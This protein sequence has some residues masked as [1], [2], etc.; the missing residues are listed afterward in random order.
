MTVDPA[1]SGLDAGAAN[2]P[3]LLLADHHRETEHACT[4]LLA[5]LYA[6]DPRELVEGFRCFERAVLD[7]IGAEEYLILPAY[8]LH[9]PS[10]ASALQAEHAQIRDALNRLGVEVDLHVARARSIT[11]LVDLLRAHAE[12]EDI[13]MYPWAQLHLPLGDRQL[14]ALRIRRSLRMLAHAR[15]RRAHAMGCRLRA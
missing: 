1:R 8:A 9:A 3:R 14:L 12:H 4:A 11:D 2:G 6:D 7:H 10:D 13:A 5:R 15:T